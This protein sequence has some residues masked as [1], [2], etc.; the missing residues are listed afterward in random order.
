MQHRAML[1]PSSPIH[2]TPPPEDDK[3]KTGYDKTVPPIQPK[4]QEKSA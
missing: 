1:W 2:Q 4:P 3:P